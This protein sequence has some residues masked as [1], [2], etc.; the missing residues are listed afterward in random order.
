MDPN[1]QTKIRLQEV[2]QELQDMTSIKGNEAATSNWQDRFD[3]LLVYKI[4][5]QE[6]LQNSAQDEL[7]GIFN[8]R[9]LDRIAQKD[10][11]REEQLL[12]ER[13][14]KEFQN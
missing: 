11:Q 2:M 4:R 1:Q 10:A 5:L 8:Q 3:F 9:R 7:S 13:K 12:E 6:R 14:Q